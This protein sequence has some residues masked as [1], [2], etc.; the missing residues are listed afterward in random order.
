MLRLL[1][2]RE[3]WIFYAASGIIIFAL[4]FYFVIDPVFK[5]NYSLN[6]EINLTR[7]KLRKY[8]QLLSQK[9]YILAK[10]NKFSLD[11]AFYGQTEN[12]PMVILSEL[13]KL[14]GLA[15]MKIV[16][17][18]QEVPLD[19]SGAKD[20]VIN[21]KTEADMEGYLKFIYDVENSLALLKIKRFQINAKPNSQVLEGTFSI[22]PLSAPEET[23][24]SISK[25]Q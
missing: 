19:A 24:R 4:L 15:G 13:E 10:N 17:M 1:T 8:M 14:A 18:R 3:K 21:L 2:S 11:P 23:R 16:D 12:M 25:K 22:V 6:R 9:D 20:A 5:E 7:V